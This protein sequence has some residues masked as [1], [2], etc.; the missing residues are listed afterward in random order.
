M[1]LT[2][3]D[4]DLILNA[5]FAHGMADRDSAQNMRAQELYRLLKDANRFHFSSERKPAR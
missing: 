5:L 4:R 2:A 3:A 1:Q